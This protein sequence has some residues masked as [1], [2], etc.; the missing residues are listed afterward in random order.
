MESWVSVSRDRHV[1][2]QHR[3][4]TIGSNFSN[5]RILVLEGIK[6]S[7]YIMT[8]EM[9]EGPQADALVTLCVIV[10]TREGSRLLSPSLRSHNYFFWTILGPSAVL[11]ARKLEISATQ[12]FPQC[13][14]HG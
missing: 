10:T 9:N 13:Q 14:P 2:Q 6:Y 7:Y 12:T 3:K 1:Y 8:L 4:E 5:K 11:L